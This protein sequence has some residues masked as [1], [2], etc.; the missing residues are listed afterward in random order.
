MKKD[1]DNENISRDSM[2]RMDCSQF[3]EALHELDRPGTPGA[4]VREGA[5]AHAETCSDC[6][7]LVTEAE[8]LDFALG[9]ISQ[10]ASDLQAPPK[11]EATLLREF[12][13]EKSQAASRRLRLQLAVVGIAAAILLVLGLSFHRP[14][15]VAP[16]KTPSVSASTVAPVPSRLGSR[17]RSAPTIPANATTIEPKATRSR[18]T[19]DKT[20]APDSGPTEYATAYV[21]LPYAYDPSDLEGGAVVRVVLPRAALISY[22]LPVEAMGV[23][24]QV[25]ADMVVSEDGTPQAIRLVAQGNPATDD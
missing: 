18:A 25:T 4:A 10:Q 19:A 24:D 13:R 22:G 15:P 12:R 5:L 14:Q 11:I 6:G 17:E 3:A 2:P 20:A 1:P 8:S 7:A 16:G 23:S 21:P 9:Q